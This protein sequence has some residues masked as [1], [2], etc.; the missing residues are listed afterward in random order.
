MRLPHDKIEAIRMAAAIHDIG[1]IS[2][3][4]EIL[5]KPAMLTDLEFCLIKNHPQ[6][7]YD[8]IKDV[9]SPWPLA[10][11][12]YQHHERIDGSGYPQGLKDA[13]IL[14]E[15]RI[16]AVADVVEAMM[17]YRPYRPMLGLEIA[18]AEIENNAGILYDRRVT[19][20]CL[21]VFRK[22]GYQIT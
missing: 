4:S 10:D 22:N 17:S 18:L 7:S 13:N 15:A 14:I 6:F 8:I 20:A 9:E 21:K 5:C 11:I 2:V 1:K 3:P 16:L 19:D 12:V